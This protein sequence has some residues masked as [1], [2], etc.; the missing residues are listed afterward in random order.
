ML[1]FTSLFYVQ[2]LLSLGVIGCIY[3]I[4]GITVFANC[5]G[6]DG[7]SIIIIYFGGKENTYINVY[8]YVCVY[9]CVYV[10]ILIYMYI[11][12]FLYIAT[13]YMYIYVCIHICVYVCICIN[14]CIYIYIYIKTSFIK[15]NG[16]LFIILNFTLSCLKL[17]SFHFLNLFII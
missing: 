11:Y 7:I 17:E 5:Y 14:V 9:V 1:N 6:F 4:P 8:I 2:Y 16:T 15:G 13:I 3:I 10:Y 12:A